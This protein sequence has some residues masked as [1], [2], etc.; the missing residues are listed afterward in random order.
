MN[1]TQLIIHGLSG[2]AIFADVVTTRIILFSLATIISSLIGIMVVIGVR[3]STEMA[4]PGWATYSVL[5][6]AILLF[7]AI[8]I[9]FFTRNT[10]RLFRSSETG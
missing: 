2:I 1:F 4:I 8:L 5:A 6:L 10:M 7:Q 3:F 9:S